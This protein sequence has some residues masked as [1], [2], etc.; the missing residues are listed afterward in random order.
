MHLP[1]SLNLR[2]IDGPKALQLFGGRPWHVTAGLRQCLITD[3]GGR[4]LRAFFDRSSRA[5]N[6]ASPSPPPALRAWN[7][8]SSF[9]TIAV[10]TVPLRRKPA[11]SHLDKLD[12]RASCEGI[13]PLN[14]FGL[15]TEELPRKRPLRVL[16]SSE[17]LLASTRREHQAGRVSTRRAG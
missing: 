15:S 14:A 10:G 9:V 2:R 16:L 5:R 3:S 13:V 7:C 12:R 1:M 11:A 8:S 4:P 17:Y 6:P